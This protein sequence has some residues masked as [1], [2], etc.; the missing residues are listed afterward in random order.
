MFSW[1]AHAV[2]GQVK[3]GHERSL[4]SGRRHAGCISGLAADPKVDSILEQY[5]IDY[6]DATVVAARNPDPRGI[7]W[8][9]TLVTDGRIFFIAQEQRLAN[10][11]N[12]FIRLPGLS[13]TYFTEKF[14]KSQ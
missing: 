14:H 10:L 4:R 6:R 7:T 1:I 3:N 5:L 12:H 2:C 13:T 11:I 8:N 9:V